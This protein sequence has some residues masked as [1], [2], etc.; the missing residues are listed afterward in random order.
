MMNN[1]P[2][3]RG[4]CANN[5]AI[6]TEGITQ[7]EILGSEIRLPLL[8]ATGLI[9]N[10]KNTARTTPAGPPI[11]VQDLQQLGDNNQRLWISFSN[12]LKRMIDEIYNFCIVIN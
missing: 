3:Q 8:R 4:V 12:D 10:P 5:I 6:V 11:E 1:A 2:M 9:S 7:Y